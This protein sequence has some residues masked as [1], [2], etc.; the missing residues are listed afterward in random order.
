MFGKLKRKKDD[1]VRGSV[2]PGYDGIINVSNLNDND[3]LSGR[4]GRINSHPGNI[5]FRNLVNQHKMT[6][7]SKQTKKLDKVKIANEIVQTI[8]NMD[9]PGRFLKQEK[10]NADE[11]IEIGDDRARKKAGQAMREKAAET[12]IELERQEL[13]QVAH[14]H[15]MNGLRTLA[16]VATSPT[17]SGDISALSGGTMTLNPNMSMGS[18]MGSNPLF[19]QQQV[20]NQFAGQAQG[21]YNMGF[22][23][24]TNATGFYNQQQEQNPS[25]SSF[26]SFQ[27]MNQFQQNQFG[28]N[29]NQAQAN[30]QQMNMQMMQNNMGAQHPV[31][32]NLTNGTSGSIAMHPNSSSSSML[33]SGMLS[34]LSNLSQAELMVLAAAQQ[35][36]QRQ[37]QQ[38]Q[39]QQQQHQL[40]TMAPLDETHEWNDQWDQSHQS[41]IRNVQNAQKRPDNDRRKFFREH[42][43]HSMTQL[44]GDQGGVSNANDNPEINAS[45]LMKQSIQS[46]NGFNSGSI[47]NM[48]MADVGASNGDLLISESSLNNLLAMNISNKTLEAAQPPDRRLSMLQAP[49]QRSLR[50]I[51]TPP[52]QINVESSSGTFSGSI[53]IQGS[54]N[55]INRSHST[56]FTNNAEE[57][58]PNMEHMAK[59]NDLHPAHSSMPPPANMAP[60]NH[61][62]HKMNHESQAPE[63]GI[64][65]DMSGISAGNNTTSSGDGDMSM[66]SR[67]SSVS[68]WLNNVQNFP[69][70]RNLTSLQDIGGSRLRLFSDNSAR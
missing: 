45:T 66:M 19:M 27:Q 11:W 14:G 12:R 34:Q 65:R 62:G 50:K 24:N 40:G 5:Q 49:K 13:P 9:P 41:N 30:A 53:S 20:P 2:P 16:A 3:V 6:Y 39:Q 44:G 18:G 59:Q 67:R 51:D 37:Q 55:D 22:Q 8:R 47:R 21:G 68:T 26:G 46:I 52:I 15:G 69:S 7:L 70:L 64:A 36:Q 10:G 33:S 48:S 63:R 42:R 58:H 28:M 4:G 57:V 56:P 31:A 38:Q 54:H 25:A 23:N 17:S 32:Q 1:E 60:M 43:E 61:S 29:M 35:Q